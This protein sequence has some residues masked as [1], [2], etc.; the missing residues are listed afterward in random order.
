MVVWPE[1]SSEAAA[2]CLEDSATETLALFGSAMAERCDRVR[3]FL[4]SDEIPAEL[5]VVVVLDIKLDGAR[6]LPVGKA[7]AI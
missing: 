5:R 2:M 1:T 3:K 7:G 4:G 6:R